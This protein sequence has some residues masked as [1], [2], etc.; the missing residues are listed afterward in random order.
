M[1]SSTR[2]DLIGA[3]ANS[4][5]STQID[6]NIET[7]N[8]ITDT[9]SMDCTAMGLPLNTLEKTKQVIEQHERKFSTGKCDLV[10]KQYLLH[11]KVAKKC[12]E[13]IIALQKKKEE[14]V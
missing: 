2:S 5:N 7:T 3:L 11:L 9:G 4:F 6:L 13:E 10:H 14:C 8:Y 1:D 12:V